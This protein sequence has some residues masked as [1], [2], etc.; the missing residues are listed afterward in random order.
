MPSSSD[1]AL[2]VSGRD[3]YVESG[4]IMVAVW[5]LCG[6]RLGVEYGDMG[7][8][9]SALERTLERKTDYERRLSPGQCGRL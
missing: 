7:G 1:V 8:R 4:S 9:Q 3:I 2:K 6:E 5:R